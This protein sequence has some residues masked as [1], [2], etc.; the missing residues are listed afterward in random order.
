MKI[1]AK[2]AHFG[3]TPGMMMS[4]SAVTSTNPMISGIGPSPAAS[5]ASARTTASTVA[6]FV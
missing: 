3:M 6:M 5:S 1:G 4:R 2:I